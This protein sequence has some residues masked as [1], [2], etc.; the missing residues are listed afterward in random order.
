MRHLLEAAMQILGT[1]TIRYFIIAGIPFLLFYKLLP[2]RFGKSKI[3][4]KTAR[5]GDF[6]REILHSMQTT[7]VFTFIALIVLF[8]PL[9]QYTLIYDQPQDYPLW[10]VPLS[11]LIG[12][13]IHDTYFYWMHRLLHHKNIF[14]YTHLVHHKSTNPSPWTSYSFHFLEACTESAVLLLLVFILPMHSITIILFTVASFI[15]NVYGHLGY[16]VA[17]KWFRHS[18][19]FK[20]LN[21]SIY[22]NMHH[23]KFK[24]NYSLYFRFWDRLL[25]T[26]NP[27]YE[28]EYDRIQLRRFGINR[29]ANS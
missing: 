21:T 16:E 24:G 23:S 19:L 14:K 27:D 29:Q 12:L 3:Q 18:F 9:K 26:E 22:H 15:I 13:I 4:S 28:K 25:K 10:W 17:P 2:V 8:S 20:I 5:S 11:L 7:V 1:T 6:I